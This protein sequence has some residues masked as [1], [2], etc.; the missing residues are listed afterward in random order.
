MY[1]RLARSPLAVAV[2]LDLR[3][4]I[5]SSAV[6]DFLLYVVDAARL[7]QYYMPLIDLLKD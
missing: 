4:K 2:E 1:L 3:T 6:R 7:S 5:S